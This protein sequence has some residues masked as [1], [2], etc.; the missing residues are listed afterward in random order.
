MSPTLS[1]ITINW[2]NAAGLKKTI[3]S[4]LSQISSLCEF[5]V[6]DGD[7]DDESKEIIDLSKDRITTVIIEPNEGIY[8]D[9]N[10]GI[11]RAKGTYCLFLNSGDWLCI[12][13]MKRVLNECTGEDIIYFKTILSYPG[14]IYKEIGYDKHL[15]F[16]SF[17]NSTIGHQTTLIKRNLFDRYGCYNEA[18]K[19][20]SDY[21]FWLK[22]LVQHNCSSRYID[23][24]LA[25]Y[26]MTGRTSVP[27]VASTTE[28][29][30]IKKE[31]IP[32][33]ILEDYDH[34]QMYEAE[35]VAFDWVKQKKYMSMCVKLIF[36]IAK[37]VAK[38]RKRLA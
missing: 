32:M 26:D 4:V 31:Y 5:I 35:N 16:K 24:P 33:R 21:E 9:M 30:R 17:F 22:T 19:L 2:N 34:W 6:V 36:T 15:T 20:H 27:S 14:R 25:Y 37:S 28:I 29:E 1:I 7:S 3:D 10:K 23:F 13:V 18:N 8:R 11:K 38:L 12:D